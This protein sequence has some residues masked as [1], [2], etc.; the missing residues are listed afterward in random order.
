MLDI[1]NSATDEK[2]EFTKS[3]KKNGNM[4]GIGLQSIREIV[5]ENG[6]A[7]EITQ[8]KNAV[9]AKVEFYIGKES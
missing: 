5:E 8:R 4:H 6:G 1:V 3:T 2:I 7:F 9:M